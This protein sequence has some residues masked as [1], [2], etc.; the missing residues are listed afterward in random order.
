MKKEMRLA[1]SLEGR[2]LYPNQAK[3]AIQ[4]VL[5]VDDLPGCYR[6]SV[7]ELFPIVPELFPQGTAYQT[8]R[9]GPEPYTEESKKKWESHYYSVYLFYHP[10][11]RIQ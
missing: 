3:I 5:L 2:F 10:H 9:G 7:P 1:N 11:Y 8:R 6:I 4:Y